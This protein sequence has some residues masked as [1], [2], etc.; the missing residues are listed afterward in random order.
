MCYNCTVVAI[1][2]RRQSN[3]THLVKKYEWKTAGSIS[4]EAIRNY[5]LEC[6]RQ[7]KAKVRTV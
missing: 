6:K 7:A 3:L 1:A 2:V 4:H 5:V